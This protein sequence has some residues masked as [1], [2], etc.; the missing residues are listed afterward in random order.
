[1]KDGKKEIQ[2]TW[3]KKKISEELK[4]QIEKILKNHIETSQ[5]IVN[6][7]KMK[8]L[9]TNDNTDNKDKNIEKL[10]SL[11]LNNGISDDILEDIAVWL[12]K[13]TLI[14]KNAKLVVKRNLWL[15]VYPLGKGD[16]LPGN[17]EARWDA[18]FIRRLHGDNILSDFWR[19][20]ENVYFKK[21]FPGGDGDRE[22]I[23]VTTDIGADVKNI[24]DE[25]GNVVKNYWDYTPGKDDRQKI[26]YSS[27]IQEILL[28]CPFFRDVIDSEVTFDLDP[29]QARKPDAAQ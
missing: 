24:I 16:V 21:A 15:Q 29:P 1:M 28:E 4:K 17:D 14:E 2:D 11:C 6:S 20:L 10:E 8:S 3:K 27:P 26:V 19:K 13:I 9:S 7:P 5:V 25:W 12:T 22:T 18:C 23:T